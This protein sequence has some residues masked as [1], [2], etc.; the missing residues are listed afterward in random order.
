M[1]INGDFPQGSQ[2]LRKPAGFAG[3]PVDSIRRYLVHNED[4]LLSAIRELADEAPTQGGSIELMAPIRV[5]API[6]VPERARGI[7][8]NCRRQP[9]ILDSG[10]QVCWNVKAPHCIWDLCTI[11]QSDNLVRTATGWV[12]AST[13]NQCH[14]R[15]SF[16]RV[17][18]FHT[19]A[20][21]RVQ[22]IHCDVLITAGGSWAAV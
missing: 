18:T 10:V 11:G 8:F 21:T 3:A 12:F 5:T 2:G 19:T 7:V 17:T 13:A 16:A 1:R 22:A 15:S 4:Q 20:A 6:V 9:L 14:I